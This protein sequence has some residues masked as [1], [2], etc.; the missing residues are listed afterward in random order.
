MNSLKEYGKIF[1]EDYFKHGIKKNKSLYSNFRWMPEISLPIANTIKKLYPGRVILD[2]GCAMGYI[3][4][5]LRL[6]GV[7]AYGY[8]I[9]EYAIKNAHPS[10]RKRLY[11]DRTKIPDVDTILGKDVMEH[12]PYYYIDEELRWMAGHCREACFIIPLGDD[13]EYRIKEYGFDT[14]HLIKENEEW[15]I[16]RFMRAGFSVKEFYHHLPGFKDNW[17]D[18]NTFGNAIFLLE[19]GSK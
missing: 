2:Y 7:E 12:I 10:V 3:V 16:L 15:W 8:D 17:Q 6:L 14:S 4:Y 9:S 5:A 11:L 1:N 13:G 18:H 19:K